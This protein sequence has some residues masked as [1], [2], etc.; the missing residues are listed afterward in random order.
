MAPRDPVFRIGADGA[1]TLVTDRFGRPQGLAFGPGDRLYVVE[2]LAGAA[3]VYELTEQG[4]AELVVAGSFVG[5]A[6][7][8]RG[9]LVLVSNETVYC[10]PSFVR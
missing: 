9:E 7:G 1:V 2:A 8:G 6:F 4:A 3:G 5:L 10:F